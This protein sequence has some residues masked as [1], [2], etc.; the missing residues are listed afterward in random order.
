MKKLFFR[1]QEGAAQIVL[2][3]IMLVLAI[4]L[5]IATKLVQQ[6]QENRSSAASSGTKLYGEKC[7]KDSECAQGK[8]HLKTC[9][10]EDKDTACTALGG[11]CSDKY[12]KLG[13]G[14]ACTVDGKDGKVVYNLCL[15]KGSNGSKRCCVPKITGVCGSAGKYICKYPATDKEL[16][17][18]G[19]YNVTP[20][21][22]KDFKSSGIGTTQY[23]WTCNGSGGG[24]DAICTA[25]KLA[26]AGVK[27]GTRTC[28]PEDWTSTLSPGVCPATGKQ[29]KTWTKKSGVVC[30]G[31]TT[32]SATEE[33]TCT[34]C[35]A[36]CSSDKKFFTT[37]NAGVGSTKVCTNGCTTTGCTPCTPN[38]SCAANT[39]I[40]STCSNGCGGTCPG[41]KQ[42]CTAGCSSDKKFFTTCTAGVGSTKVCTNGCTTAG[43][44]PPCTAGC[45]SDKKFFTTCTAGV[46]STT[47]CASGTNCRTI[48][49]VVKC[50][51]NDGCTSG[52][53]ICGSGN[54]YKSCIKDS[55]GSWQWG[56][57][58]TACTNNQICTA[59]TIST[60]VCHDP[61]M[62]NLDF[63]IKFALDG[64][65]K[66]NDKC[67][68]SDW[69]IR[70]KIVRFKTN[71]SANAEESAIGEFALKKCDPV[72][73]TAI[74]E[75]IY[76]AHITLS[77][78]NLTSFKGT[79]VLVD[80]ST[81]HIW[82]KYGRNNQAS[83]WNNNSDGLNGSLEL[84]SN[85]SLTLDFSQL[86]VLAGDVKSVGGDITPDDNISDVDYAYVK[87]LSQPIQNGTLV[88]DL[89]GNCYVNSGDVN[90]IR[91]AL[92]VI[93]SNIY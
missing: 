34:P 53:Q 78:G 49:S 59:G 90:L 19:V 1:N 82:T 41:T 38:C 14:K 48:S 32:H 64:V 20:A 43:C 75:I 17:S 29:T 60:A 55:D 79:A 54:T 80:E 7:S 46:G 51:K 71:S 27:C 89:D 9:T 21:D 87:D 18:A 6:N 8:C 86:P 10:V 26:A 73:T 83:M 66:D 72:A 85:G 50:A 62:P 45:S 69:K 2:M 24:K 77:P 31:G 28:T 56:T 88:A 65:V 44:T 68:S 93:P 35:T 37:C 4:S 61:T 42:A 57:T 15:G 47:I 92:N 30:V 22:D 39:L 40:G 52:Q 23:K 13:N 16:C 33:V 11:K 84:T 81:R 74:G 25:I 3:L 67:V 5:P 76:C 12:W 36:G 70:V 58:S 63:N 91:K